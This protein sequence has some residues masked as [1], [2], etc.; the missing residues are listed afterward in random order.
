M[1]SEGTRTKNMNFTDESLWVGGSVE[2]E[3][4]ESQ[5]VG[6]TLYYTARNLS[7]QEIER[8][9]PSATDL[10][11]RSLEKV[12][13]EN[14]V[15]SIL[16]YHE[17][18]N[19]H[20]SWGASIRST[21]M[22][23]SGKG[24]LKETLLTANSG[25]VTLSTP[26]TS[27]INSK[28]FI[29]TRLNVGMAYRPSNDWLWSVDLHSHEGFKYYDLKGSEAATLV[30]NRFVTNLSFGGERSYKDWLKFR[31]GVFTNFSAHPDPDPSLLVE[32]MDHVDMLGFSA[33]VSLI[34]EKKIAYTFGGYYSGGW[35]RSLQ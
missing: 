18:I 12:M 29:P 25:T 30:H 16:G 11:Y 17:K 13:K 15:V 6:L 5:R 1:F 31:A 7:K 24:D 27:G 33:N 26:E 3:L 14:A 19:D 8:D 28:V 21:L 35:G 32:Q 2:K 10:S 34:S 9:V 22:A 20:W 23:I 4:N